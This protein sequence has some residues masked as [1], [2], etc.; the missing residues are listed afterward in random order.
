MS[1]VVKIN[2]IEDIHDEQLERELED[3]AYFVTFHY[4]ISFL[5]TWN[6]ESD[7]H[8]RRADQGTFWLGLK[9]TF[10]SLLL[11]WWGPI[12]F[13]FVL[14]D[15]FRNFG[16]NDVTEEALELLGYYEE[17]EQEKEIE[18]R[19]ARRHSTLR[20]PVYSRRPNRKPSPRRGRSSSR[21]GRSKKNQDDYCDYSDYSAREHTPDLPNKS[22]D[23]DAA[24]EPKPRERRGQRGSGSGRDGLPFRGRN[25]QKD[26]Y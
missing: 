11:G 12:G 8:Y 13:V 3:G 7:F 9:Y 16:G 1:E 6:N 21:S 5:W 2:G 17:E 18:E 20:Q 19:P 4:T 14:M 23:V 26:H 15:V 25:K 10:L 24:P 22:I